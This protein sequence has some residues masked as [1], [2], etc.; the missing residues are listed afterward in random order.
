MSTFTQTHSKTITCTRIELLKVQVRITLRKTLKN[1][2]ESEL[3][4]VFDV[5][6]E[7]KYIKQINVYAMGKDNLCRGMIEIK[8]D[9]NLH[10]VRISEG[11]D[12][13]QV[14][15]AWTK[16]GTIEVDEITKL[17]QKFVEQNELKTVWQFTF[18]D[19]IDFEAAR[20]ELGTVAANP[21]LWKGVPSGDSYSVSLI[22]EM[23]I[24]VFFSENNE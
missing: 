21:P 13:L 7:K 12:L 23:G 6:L 10:K 2:N 1:I 22:D 3:K 4:R 8:I 14:E 24:G 5:G 20:R 9:W 17:F 16:E 15:E 19:G 11:N 18:S